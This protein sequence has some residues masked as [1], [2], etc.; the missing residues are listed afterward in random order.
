MGDALQTIP[1][2]LYVLAKQTG[3]RILFFRR[4]DSRRYRVLAIREANPETGLKQAKAMLVSQVLDCQGD[5]RLSFASDADLRE[6]MIH[7]DVSVMSLIDWFDLVSEEEAIA[8]TE[9]FRLRFAFQEVFERA[10]FT[11]AESCPG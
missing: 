10:R 2:F 11:T 1:G 4:S 6:F 3:E 9:Q 7:W 5:D 8:P